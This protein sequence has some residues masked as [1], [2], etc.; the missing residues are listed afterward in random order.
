MWLVPSN[1]YLEA[2]TPDVVELGG[3]ALERIQI[4]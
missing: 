2:L 3:G 4:R 1:P